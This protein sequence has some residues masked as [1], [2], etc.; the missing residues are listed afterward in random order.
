MHKD[1]LDELGELALGTR[2]KRVSERMLADAA[3]VYDHF[4]ITVQP[5]WFALLALLDKKITVSVVEASEYLGLSQPALSQFCRQLISEGLI[6]V[7]AGKLDSRKKV[8]QLSSKGRT[9]VNLMKPIWQAVDLAAKE[10][11]EELG[12]QFYQSLLLFEKAH[13]HRSL[14]HRTQNQFTKLVS[15]KMQTETVNIIEF[16]SELATYFELINSQWIE[17]MFVLEEVDKQVL[18]HPQQ[19]IINSGGKIWFA[20]HP[21]LG[22]VGTC[23]LL[24]KGEGKYE[25][26]KMGVLKIARGLKIGEILLQHVIQEAQSFA[27]ESLFLLTNSKCEAAIH[28]YE[29]NGFV[30]D[31]NIMSSYGKIYQRCDVAMRWKSPMNDT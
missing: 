10:L 20:E 9:Q 27:F 2:L 15:D 18:C 23:A 26:T 29:K 30:H 3:K 13:K 25:L 17:E 28:L 12:N 24:N 16:S 11:S 4:G 21:Q 6:T 31:K 8:M 1:F 22:I 19:S 7:S 14:L 5:K